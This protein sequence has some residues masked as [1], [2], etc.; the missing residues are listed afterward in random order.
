MQLAALA[1]CRAVEDPCGDI[2]DGRMGEFRS[3]EKLECCNHREELVIN[4]IIITIVNHCVQCI[5]I[6][7]RSSVEEGASA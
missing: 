6:I 2:A 7:R 3:V 5:I 1:Q 4:I